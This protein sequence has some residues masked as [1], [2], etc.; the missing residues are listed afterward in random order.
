MKLYKNII[1]M[2]GTIGKM[3]EMC[4]QIYHRWRLA[5]SSAPFADRALDLVRIREYRSGLL[6]QPL[7]AHLS[8]DRW[9]FGERPKSFEL[10]SIW[11]H[12]ISTAIGCAGFG[13]HLQNNH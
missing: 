9:L 11:A 4:S 10:P 6:V 5:H 13:W 7:H 3:C 8:N 2:A 12:G 1:Y